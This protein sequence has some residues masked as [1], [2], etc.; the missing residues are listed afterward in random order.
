LYAGGAEQEPDNI[1]GTLSLQLGLDEPQDTECWPANWPVLQVFSAMGTQW[2]V[3]YGGYVGL[4]YEALQP[5]FEACG[6][7]KKARAEMFHSLRIME[8][9]ALSVINER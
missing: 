1:I 9:E 5:V 3:S 8:N 2:M 7:K 6:I 4:R